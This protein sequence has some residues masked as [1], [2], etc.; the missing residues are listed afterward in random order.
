MTKTYTDVICMQLQEIADFLAARAREVGWSGVG[1]SPFS[2][3]A[4][5][6]GYLGYS[7]GKLD[8]VT[9]VVS[10]VRKSEV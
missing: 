7:G 2:D 1:S 8:D 10:I 5:D 9:V 4:R 3:A 6:A